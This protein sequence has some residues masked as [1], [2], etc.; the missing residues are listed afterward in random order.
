V[1][2]SLAELIENQITK[3]QNGK[4]EVLDVWLD[5]EDK[6]EK[7]TNKKYFE[8]KDEKSSKFWEINLYNSS[9]TTCYG[10]IGT[11]GQI[12][13][14]NFETEIK[15][16]KEY[17]KLIAEKTKKGYVEIIT[18][19]NEN[20]PT[21][22]TVGK[23][24][25][26]KDIKQSLPSETWAY[27]RGET[28]NNEFDDEWV[29]YIAEDI[30]VENLDLENLKETFANIDEDV[31]IV[32]VNGNLTAKN[33]FNEE[34]DGCTGLVI[35]GNLYCNN[36]VVGG[37]EIYVC[38]DL[39][40]K[41][42]FWGDYN[43]GDLVV[44][45][46]IN[47]NILIDT[48]YSLPPQ[49]YPESFGSEND[50]VKFRFSDELKDEF[51]I[52]DYQRVAQ[53]FLEEVLQEKD[54]IDLDEIYGWNTFLSRYN[55]LE[56]LKNRKSL[57]KSESEI[58]RFQ[59]NGYKE[60]IE[61][62]TE[63]KEDQ[64][65]IHK[66]IDSFE[67][68]EENQLDIDTFLQLSQLIEDEDLCFS[69]AFDWKASVEDV[70]T[71]LDRFLDR[72]FNVKLD[73]PNEKDFINIE[74]YISDLF[75]DFDIPLRK[76]GFQLTFIENG[77]DAHFAVLHKTEDYKKVKDC[78]KKIGL[79]SYESEGA[80][81]FD[82]DYLNVPTIFEE[83]YILNSKDLTIPAKTFDK[84]FE[85]FQDLDQNES[86]IFLHKSKAQVFVNKAHK[87]ESDGAKVDKSIYFLTD[88]GA[89]IFF[90]YAPKSLMQ[91]LT[92]KQ[93]DF[94]ILYKN[95]NDNIFQYKPIFDVEGGVEIIDPLWTAFLETLERGIYF[96]KQFEEIVEIK[97]IQTI[98][99]YKMV[100]EKY[101]NSWTDADQMPWFGDSSYSFKQIEDD[102]YEGIRV[103]RE[104]P[105]D[106]QDYDAESFYYWHHNTI[107]KGFLNY[108]ANY[109]ENSHEIY[110][111]YYSSGS[112]RVPFYDYK[113]FQEAIKYWKKALITL[114]KENEDYLTAVKEEQYFIDL[115]KSLI[116][117]QKEERKQNYKVTKPFETIEIDGILF[118]LKDRNEAQD[119]LKVCIDF[120]ENQVYDA[121]EMLSYDDPD[122]DY[123][124]FFLVAENEVTAEKLDL[125]TYPPDNEEV[126]ILGYI[127]QKNLTIESYINAENLDSSPALIVLG[128]IKATNIILSGNVFYFGNDLRCD[129]LIGEYNRG[130][131]FVKGDT[132]AWLI[133]SDDMPLNFN[134]FVGI[135]AVISKY[136]PAI[137][138]LSKLQHEDGTIFYKRNYLPSTHF[139][140]D[141]VF[142]HYLV[143][144]ENGDDDLIGNYFEE[145]IKQNGT[146]ID[147]DKKDIFEYKNFP[148]QLA[149]MVSKLLIHDDLKTSD[150]IL[151]L[152]N[153]DFETFG[154]V[155]FDFDN[156]KYA[157]IEHVFKGFSI[158]MRSIFDI[159]NKTF[160]IYLEYLDNDGDSEFMWEGDFTDT[161][162][163]LKTVKHAVILTFQ[164]LSGIKKAVVLKNYLNDENDYS[165]NET[166]DN[167]DKGVSK[168]I[169]PNSFTQGNATSES[170]ENLQNQYHFS[171]NYAAFLKTQ[172]GFNAYDFEDNDNTNR[173][174]LQKSNLKL[175]EYYQDLRSLFGANE[176]ISENED[177]IFKDYL[178][179]IGE[180]KGG[181][182]V[183]EV[184]HGKF[185]GYIGIIDHEMYAGSDNMEEFIEAFDLEDFEKSNIDEKTNMLCDED[186]MMWF[187]AKNMQSFIENCLIFVDDEVRVIESKMTKE[188]KEL[189][190]EKTRNHLFLKEMYEDQ[191]FP[192]NCVDMG[193]EILIDLCFQIEKT[194]P[195]SLE[196]LYKLTHIATEK[197]NDLQEDFEDNDSEIETAARDCIGEN[198]AF[199]A[200]S[201]GFNEADT[202][203]LIATREW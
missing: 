25:K 137:S 174:Y 159:E 31:F 183:V 16:E 51:T 147:H 8:F 185:K 1:A 13:E 75:I 52:D 121:F 38:G 71:E 179:M 64:L 131:L 135:E 94:K 55:V 100:Q 126:Y 151:D 127:F 37:Q 136:R 56:I 95:I 195:K 63:N 82:I 65:E 111:M 76:N 143:K 26:F 141:I 32:F 78:I 112:K 91:K 60:L 182:A 4:R 87:R 102:G 33:I 11:T 81:H 156:R 83:K 167:E 190:N 168:I 132:T 54:E 5:K 123:K 191:Y 171:S 201:Y 197:F 103:A 10:K 114:P 166:T 154:F 79:N 88:D 59:L 116:S 110:G 184:L 86:R 133:Y 148:N 9:L 115:K 12:S 128:D 173:N 68:E 20:K 140:S 62:C 50:S 149:E 19:A 97:E 196:E 194:L 70:V 92:N 108:Q 44:K 85:Y 122:Q 49:F 203:E 36:I 74:A 177:N 29:Y 113:L 77:T 42:V 23:L 119:L 157:Q 134:Q 176:I 200:N 109:Y 199:I 45:G 72:N 53:L 21:E 117:K 181:N 146:L 14:K 145:V 24:V 104:I 125:N 144:N 163:E 138:L 47:V 30:V 35:L 27:S 139:L 142:D 175:D 158:R 67:K 80:E 73:L 130:K 43:H 155:K 69:L 39:N 7:N 187:Y 18:T 84:V 153:Q 105:N 107:E 186:I 129:S 170:I 40:V 2:N 98:L 180:D 150:S 118:T 61:M 3:L 178:L 169:F 89:E 198:F 202:E 34:T 101:P 57:L 192:N 189:T 41:E 106:D 96:K 160:N 152:T 193:K 58:S 46:K 93:N 120:D 28:N 66:I 188:Q 172:N 15:A 124:S 99:N 165:D 162:F 6:D 22:T 90:W 48:D 161:T 164:I 17:H